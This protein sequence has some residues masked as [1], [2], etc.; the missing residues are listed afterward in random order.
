M[1]QSKEFLV[2]SDGLKNPSAQIRE[3]DFEFIVDGKKYPC[4]SY[5]AEFIS[6]KIAEIRSK[7]PSFKSFTVDIKDPDENFKLVIKLMKGYEVEA[8]VQQS[9]FLRRVGL[10]LENQEISEAFSFLRN[11][12]L[13]KENAVQTLLEKQE[14]G[15]DVSRELA[16]ITRNFFTID[17]E[18]LSSLDIATIREIIT[19]PQ[20]VISTEDSLFDFITHLIDIKGDDYRELLVYVNYEVLSEA[21]SGLIG[22]YITIETIHQFPR[23]WDGL[24]KRLLLP[25]EKIRKP[26]RYVH[27]EI[28]VPLKEENS[29][30]G[31]FSYITKQLKG[32]NPVDA[33]EI[34]VTVG[35]NECS[36]SPAALMNYK[37]SP[38]RWYLAEHED[39]WVCFDFKKARVSINAYT[40]SSGADSSYWEY[41]V[42]FT[43]E[44]SNDTIKW[45][46]I[47]VRDHDTDMGG[48]DKTHTWRIKNPCPLFRY[49]RF[50]LRNVTRRGGL[51][52][53]R[54]EL[55]GAY[56]PPE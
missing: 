35:Q 8:N 38:S 55:F 32:Q 54:M 50:R 39:N 37:N 29:F 25:T 49:I 42:S 16:Y 6:P 51:Y 41:P 23:I 30:D 52:T 31:I 47:D 17:E 46:E 7:D 27:K 40:I 44:G 5:F 3:C 21:C 18:E 33:G 14:S 13:T 22:K 12:N 26:E 11:K 4:S 43:W 24:Q 53:P 1:F 10:I 34:V 9:V 36:V 2:T 48:N 56:E 28:L 20:L 19:S 45:H 15:K